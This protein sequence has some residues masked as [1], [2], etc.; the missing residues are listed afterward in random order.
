M[1]RFLFTLSYQ[2][3]HC[4]LRTVF[5]F[6]LLEYFPLFELPT[7]LSNALLPLLF[8]LLRSSFLV[9]LFLLLG[10]PELLV[11]RRSK[12]TEWKLALMKKR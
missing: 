7:Q 8:T 1:Q 3:I 5:D 11:A 4:A 2:N 12:S 9:F 6:V 10:D